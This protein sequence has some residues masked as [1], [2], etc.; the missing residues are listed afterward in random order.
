MTIEATTTWTVTVSQSIDSA[1]R[2]RLAEGADL[3]AD[4]SAFVEE[5]VRWR[6]LDQS[7]TDAHAA[8]ADLDPE[9]AQALLDDAVDS[10]RAQ[11]RREL[12]DKRRP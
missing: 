11:M 7:M 10:V 5:A 3:A 2:A 12:A 9:D 6:L 8:F 4:V 1:L